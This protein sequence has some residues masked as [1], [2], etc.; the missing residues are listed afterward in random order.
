MTIDDA[1]QKTGSR[2][3]RVRIV[4]T[5]EALRQHRLRSARMAGALEK[6]LSSKLSSPDTLMVAAG[7]GFTFEKMSRNPSRLLLNHLLKTATQASLLFRA[8]S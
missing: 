8:L 1:D 3:L 4:A 2:S 5:E 6:R 7:L